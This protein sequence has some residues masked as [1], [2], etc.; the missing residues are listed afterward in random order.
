ML[1]LEQ[2]SQMVKEHLGLCDY[3]DGTQYTCKWAI[4]ESPLSGRGLI[5]T[6]DIMPGEVLFVDRPLIYG[7]RA[8]SSVEQG[9]TVCAKLDS[10][11]FYKCSKCSLLLCS[12]QCQNSDVHF[13]DCSIICRWNLKKPV[14]DA[15]DNVLSRALTPIRALMLTN[16]QK[17][18]MS[19]MQ[20]HSDAPVHGSEVRKLKPYYEI[21]EE[22][23]QL[24][25]L[26]CCALDTN[27]FQIATPYGKKEMSMRGLYPVSGLMNHNCVPNTRYYFNSDLQMTVKA[28]KPIRAGT[29]IFSCYTGILWGTPARRVYLYKTKHFLCK[30]DRCSDPTE[31]GTLLGALKCFSNQCH[32]Y[33]LPI[34][35]LKT[36][37]AWRCLECEMRVPNKN[38]CAIQGALGSLMGTLNFD[39]VGDLESFL[40]D[41]ITKYIPKTNQIVIDLQC[42]L[43]VAF[44]EAEGYRWHELSESRLSLKESLCRG[45]LRTVAALGVGDAHLRGLLLYHLHA[46]LA[47]RA[48]RSPDLYEEIK[49]E[50]EST[51]EQA[52]HI[53]Q[54]DISAPPDLELRRRYLGPGCD[55]PQEERFFI[56]DA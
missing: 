44:G 31:R 52:Y 12:E 24:M 4:N 22:E 35:P 30:C 48:R 10:D 34:D 45:T 42:R 32:G 3:I 50:I 41:R 51:I 55:K 18:L 21:P 28:V 53:L 33:L 49:A 26:A 23:E 8:S 1:S 19:C 54:G 7:P 13:N 16:D 2:L 6:E 38:I 47:E 46:V 17:V 11:S 36:S 29:E 39:N 20:A 37:S 43:I 14:E 40:V 15:D 25:I 27:A 9:C 5:A 56:L